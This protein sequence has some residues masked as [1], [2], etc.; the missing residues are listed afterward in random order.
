LTP[1]SVPGQ[2]GRRSPSDTD[3]DNNPDGH[4]YFDVYDTVN[5]YGKG[6]GSCLMMT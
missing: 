2:K 3:T 4:G 5:F 6:V 1:G